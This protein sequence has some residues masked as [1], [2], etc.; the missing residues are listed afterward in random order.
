[1]VKKR[2]FIRVEV[3]VPEN[4]TSED[5][6]ELGH[7]ELV[8]REKLVLSQEVTLEHALGFFERVSDKVQSEFLFQPN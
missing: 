7:M 2:V 8:V 1:M 4:P 5:L 6:E 3:S